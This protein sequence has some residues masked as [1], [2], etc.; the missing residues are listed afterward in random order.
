[1]SRVL[2][3]NSVQIFR[4]YK[5]NVFINAMNYFLSQLWRIFTFAHIA[6]FFLLIYIQVTVATHKQYVLGY[7]DLLGGPSIEMLM[8]WALTIK[9]PWLKEKKC[10]MSYDKNHEHVEIVLKLYLIKVLP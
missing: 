2:L 8:I 4:T 7:S 9:K 3:D 5:P 10:N 1:M 6:N